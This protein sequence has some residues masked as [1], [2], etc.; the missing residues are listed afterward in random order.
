MKLK[1]ITAYFEKFAP[2]MYQ[3]SYDNSG[4]Q[5]G[6]YSMDLTGA[7]V[8]LDLTEEVLDEALDKGLNL[9]VTHHPV[10]FGGLKSLT[11]RNL[12][13][14][15]IMKA[16]KNDVAIYAAHTNIDAIEKGVNGKI[17]EKLELEKCRILEPME[18]VLKKLVVFVPS[19]YAD[20]VR[21]TLFENG[22]GHIG[23]YD[24]CSFNLEGK[25]T[26]R[27]GEESNPFVGEKGSLQ[28]EEEV[29]IETIF[30]AHEKGRVIG[31]MLQVHPYEEV[32]YDIYS[33]DNKYQKV[34]MGMLGELKKEMKEGEFLQMLKEKF[35]VDCIRHTALLGKKIKKV[36]V[37][38][39]AGSFLLRKAISSGADIF[40][41]GDFKYHQFFDAEGRIIIADIGHFESEQFTRELFYEL[42]TKKFPTFAVHLSD[43]NTNPIKYF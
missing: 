11:G 1:E 29:R 9:I 22:A 6:N 25:G 38:G 33:L 32:A 4:L 5:V 10:I 12:S 2:L 23:N 34:G 28:T 17:C 37:S 7:L 36:A 13:E 40:V 43:V 30:P 42:L 14:R 41:S 21:E 31:A 3:E 26:F 8:T 19:G 35:N 39:G 27:G 16:I 24:A 18:S 15:V 20:K